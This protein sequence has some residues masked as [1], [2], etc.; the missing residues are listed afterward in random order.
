MPQP[1]PA[2]LPPRRLSRRL[3]C[4]LCRSPYHRLAT[5]SVRGDAASAAYSSPVASSLVRSP[6]SPPLAPSRHRCLCPRLCLCRGLRGHLCRCCR[7]CLFLRL[8]PLSPPL[9]PP[10]SPRP[11]LQ[12]SPPHLPLQP[13]LPL[14]PS[15]ALP[16]RLHICH[17]RR[18]FCQRLRLH[19]RFCRRMGVGLG[20]RGDGAWGGWG[21]RIGWWV[22]RVL[23]GCWGRE[24]G[25]GRASVVGARV[26]GSGCGLGC[27]RGGVDAGRA[28]GASRRRI[29]VSASRG[30]V[31]TCGTPLWVLGQ[32]AVVW[33]AA[34]AGRLQTISGGGLLDAFSDLWHGSR[35]SIAVASVP[36]WGDLVA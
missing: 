13:P 32:E 21:W 11:R 25:G 26:C 12:P 30:V 31:A 14:P 35:C 27:Q 18:R 20:D 36:T 8:W 17:R 19:L 22:F 10:P 9:P 7:L 29:A 24:S 6:L 3:C 23:G 16:A 2:P 28:S 15:P 34:A 5:A 1:L 4:S 33:K